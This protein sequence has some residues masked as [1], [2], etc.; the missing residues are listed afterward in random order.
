[1]NFLTRKFIGNSVFLTIFAVAGAVPLA[2][3]DKVTVTIS[4][5]DVLTAQY[6]ATFLPVYSV[7]SIMVSEGQT[8]VPLTFMNQ[9]EIG[10]LGLVNP[11]SA[12]APFPQAYF[13]TI[14]PSVADSIGSFNS[15]TDQPIGFNLF[16]NT[17]DGSLPSGAT[18]SAAGSSVDIGLLN[19]NASTVDVTIDDERTRI[20]N[21]P[22]SF[23]TWYAVAI[24]V[25]ALLG[26][27]ELRRRRIPVLARVR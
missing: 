12:L 10:T 25:G 4:P 21:V 2:R 9:Y 18:L 6:D 20:T 3:A 14:L 16:V 22:D 19:V 11:G 8:D 27:S 26:L 13:P 24:G 15:F 5:T 17:D 23:P 7:Y 1:M